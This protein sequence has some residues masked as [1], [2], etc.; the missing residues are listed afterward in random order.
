ML[1]TLFFKKEFKKTKPIMVD[2]YFAR[3]SEQEL[4]AGKGLSLT[5][6]LE[7]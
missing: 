7:N 5:L 2:L 1:S 3:V 4:K 6:L